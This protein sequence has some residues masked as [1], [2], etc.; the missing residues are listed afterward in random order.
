MPPDPAGEKF[1]KVLS[2][3][4]G[5]TERAV[6]KKNDLVAVESKT[7]TRWLNPEFRA[8]VAVGATLF[9]QAALQNNRV[10]DRIDRLQ[11]GQAVMR[12]RLAA[13]VV[14]DGSATTSP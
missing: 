9:G 4:K 10:S 13:V 3:H 8:I 12:E 6:V 14:K 2:R 7:R 11:E 1:R 5:L